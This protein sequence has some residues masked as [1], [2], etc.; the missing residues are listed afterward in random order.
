MKI[1]LAIDP[2]AKAARTA[3]RLSSILHAELTVLFVHD[4]SWNE[5]LGSDWLSGSNSR[6]AFLE[7]V[8]DDEAQEDARTQIVFKAMSGSAAYRWK[9]VTGRVTDEILREAAQGY[10]LLIMSNPFRRGLEVVR[11]A[12]EVVARRSPCDLVLV[13]PGEG[14]E[15]ASEA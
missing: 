9:S 15:P 2:N 5:Y 11:D 13:R 12:V 3:L 14:S 4:A 8:R 1:L 6:G 10:D 7:Y